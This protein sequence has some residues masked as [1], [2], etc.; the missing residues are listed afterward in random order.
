MPDLGESTSRRWADRRRPVGPSRI[1][2]ALRLSGGGGPCPLVPDPGWAPAGMVS[3]PG[4][5]AQS[6][7]SRGLTHVSSGVVSSC[8]SF[9]SWAGWGSG[10]GAVRGLRGAGWR[11]RRQ[12]VLGLS[13][14]TDGPGWLFADRVGCVG[15]SCL[16]SHRVRNPVFTFCH[17]AWLPAVRAPPVWRTW[18][19]EVALSGAPSLSSCGPLSRSG[20]ELGRTTTKRFGCRPAGIPRPVL[21]PTARPHEPGA[22]RV[23][24]PRRRKG[25]PCL[26]TA[27]P[28]ATHG[29]AQRSTLRWLNVIAPRG[30]VPR[31]TA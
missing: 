14:V 29:S 6:P 19:G 31:S 28:A 11:C 10:V 18:F 27:P 17:C 25:R 30:S 1:T 2:R 23:R 7:V 20:H 13:L 16:G 5:C 8:C 21:T 9:L 26:D 12:G 15:I 22:C 24:T 3:R 4:G